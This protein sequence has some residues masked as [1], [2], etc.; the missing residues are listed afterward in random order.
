MYK[1]TVIDS[2]AAKLAKITKKSII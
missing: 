1:L 2:Y